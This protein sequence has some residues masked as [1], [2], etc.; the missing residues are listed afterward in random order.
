MKKIAFVNGKGGS[1][2]TTLCILTAIAASKSNYHVGIIDTDPQQSMF[3]WITNTKPE[4]IE[5]VQNGHS[6]DLII[7]DTPP[8]LDDPKLV[9]NLQQVDDIIVVSS[10]SPADILTTERT[11]AMLQQNKLDHRAK[12]L[13]NQYRKNTVLAKNEESI[14][15]KFPIRRMANKLATRQAYQMVALFGWDALAGKNVEINEVQSVILEI[16]K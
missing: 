2:K 8:R 9:Q 1:G 14:V 10:L 13:I 6:Y 11:I 3:S 4:N 12:L 16:F 5:P 7:M 15:G